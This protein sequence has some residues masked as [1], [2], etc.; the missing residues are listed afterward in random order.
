MSIDLIIIYT[1]VVLSIILLGWI[2]R[3]EKKIKLFT[4]GTGITNLEELF[5]ALRTDIRVLGEWKNQSI[6]MFKQI[7][8]R[9]QKSIR[10]VETVR[11]NPFKG[12]G[13]GGNQSFA[14]AF[15]D[16]KGNGVVFSSLHARDRISIFSKPLSNFISTYELSEEERAVIEKAKNSIKTV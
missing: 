12:T 11:F 3:L 13:V 7:D 16:E 2:I 9:L 14:T 6:D 1:L 5:K 10:G 4:L 8:T 15:I